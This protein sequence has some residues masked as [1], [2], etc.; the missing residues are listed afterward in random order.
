M[1][2]RDKIVFASL[3]LFN[4]HGERNITTN[5][6]AA[7]LN[8]SPGN[9]YYHF[10]N[11]EDII[12][13]IFTMYESNLENGSKPYEDVSI[14]VELLLGYFDAMFYT[15]WQY[16]FMY[17]NLADILS[18]DEALKQRYTLAQ[19]SVLARSSNVLKQLKQDGFL[20]VED[21]N[22][23][24]LADTMKMIVSYWISYQL[25][26]SGASKITKPAIYKGLLRVVMLFKAY[27]TPISQPTF[28]R[29]EQHYRELVSQ[30]ACPEL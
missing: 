24:E 19:K 7:H 29:L 18:R 5:H 13:S 12:N 16:R 1:K 14:D 9:L 3:E 2:T 22:I 10:R 21:D 6:I 8:I 30:D 27:S 11:K 20:N 26:Q 25:T 17:A 4:E 28:A 15:M 23:V